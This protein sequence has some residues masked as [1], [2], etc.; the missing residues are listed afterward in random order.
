MN[1]S[2]SA[3]QAVLAHHAADTAEHF[4]SSGPTFG[5]TDEWHHVARGGWT[6]LCLESPAGGGRSASEAVAGFEALGLAGAQRGA[7]FAVGAHLFGAAKAVENFGTETCRDTWQPQLADGGAVGALALTEPAGGSELTSAQT[8]LVSDG[9]DGFV[10]NG[11]KTLVTNATSAGLFIVLAREPDAA[12]PMNVTVVAVPAS[13]PGIRRNP[14]E[15]GQGLRGADMGEVWFDQCAVRPDQ[16]LGRRRAGLSVVLSMMQWERTCILAGALGALSRD[17][18]L[19]KQALSARRDARGPL[20][21]HQ[22]VSHGLARIW[23]RIEA[24]RLMMYRAAWE[25]DQGSDVLLYPALSKL[26]LSETMLDCSVEL[27][28]LMGGAGWANAFGLG[29]AV[30]D[31]IAMSVASGTDEIQLNLIASRLG[32]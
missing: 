25:L 10:L 16:I 17:F 11:S 15:G 8:T 9:R 27:Q 19:V 32:L 3:T 5:G 26:T 6:G 20:T 21:R 31:A 30:Q 12:A 14:L 22:A 4:G 23:Q 1:F 18:S 2:L 13:I 28:R 7:L 24:A 29:E